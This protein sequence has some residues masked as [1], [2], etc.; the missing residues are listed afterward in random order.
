MPERSL[1][2]IH[3]AVPSLR[4]VS[5]HEGGAGLDICFGQDVV[6]SSLAGV[7]VHHIESVVLPSNFT[8]ACGMLRQRQW[9]HSG[10]TDDYRR[11]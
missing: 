2:T 10:N 9:R 6:C 3:G 8:C 5:K 11:P 4:Q 1:V 7:R